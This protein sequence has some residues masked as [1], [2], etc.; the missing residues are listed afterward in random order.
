MPWQIDL[1]TM[2]RGLIGDM[3]SSNYSDNRIR[4]I[5]AIA[6]FE[7]NTSTGI[8]KDYDINI[9][10]VTISPD[11]I[12]GR[13]LNF[14]VMTAYKAAVIIVQGEVRNQSLNSITISDG[15]SSINLT[16]VTRSLQALYKDLSSKYED[17]LTAY[18]FEESSQHGQA[19]LG[20][21]SPGSDLVNWYYNSDYRTNNF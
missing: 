16:D 15:T 13:D 6:A 7:V 1:V 17:L 21:Y 19:I 14:S 5:V 4:Q 20:P 12:E 18:V 2:V 9:S 8:T 10:R 11:P 3:A